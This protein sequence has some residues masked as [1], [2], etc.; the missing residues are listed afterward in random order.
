MKYLQWEH[1][2][3]EQLAGVIRKKFIQELKIIKYLYVQ[4][5]KTNAEICHHLKISAPKSF[6]MLNELINGNL[7]EKQGR[8]ES[9]GGRKPDLYGLRENSL[10]VLAIDMN[11]YQTN[12]SIFNNNNINITGVQT[13]S[14]PL[15]NDSKT[16]DKLYGYASEL[17][18]SSKID[19]SKLMGIGIS[20]PGLVD[21][22]NGVN[23]TYLRPGKKAL[24]DLLQEKFN[25]P[26]FIENDANAVAL[27]EYRF[28]LA[29][30]KKDALV[31]FMDWGVG[32]GL[33]LD[34]KLFRG[35]SG[36]A[37]EFSHIPMMEDGA[38]CHCGKHGCLESIASGL[39]LVNLAKEG[40]KSG[41]STLLNDLTGNDP[42]KLEAKLVMDAARNGDQFAINILSEVGYNL[43]KGIAVL[44]QLF[45]PE[46][47]V[48]SG[49]MAQA[50][51]YITVPIQHALNIYC[52]SQ[53][54]DRTS[55]VVSEMG[56]KIGMMGAIAVVMENIFENYSSR[57]ETKKRAV[58]SVGASEGE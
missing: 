13:Y 3:I 50:G 58:K 18:K 31:I 54:R 47:I 21:S 16:I 35:T 33:I 22:R 5:P 19:A 55:I 57:P 17:I 36:F 2:H 25:R 9:I 53:L 29:K 6:S 52:M 7:L 46:L 56:E 49:R 41:K 12:M 32:L 26:V 44:I 20:I 11:K 14:I 4:G 37:G 40:I 27:A 43:G 38:L 10:F 51:E 1:S 42:D 8:G 24:R 23:H 28:G 30:G 39:T 15:D 34:G 45:N 48:L